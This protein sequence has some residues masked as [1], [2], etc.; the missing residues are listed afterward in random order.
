[1][2][3]LNAPATQL[4]AT[5]CCCCGR[6][7]VDAVSVELG[8]GPECRAGYDGNINEAQRKQC[9]NLTHS[10]AVAAQEGNIEAVRS[11]ANEVE[12]LGLPELAAKIRKRFINAERQAKIIITQNG[13]VISV[14]TPYKRSEKAEFTAAWRAIP[15]RRWFNGRNVIPDTSKRELWEL[16][17]RFFPGQ[18]AKGPQG[19]FK[20]P[21]SPTKSEA[22]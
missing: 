10:A 11:F 9:N 22:A 4:L 14:K 18:Y 15:G 3:Y 12:A 7:L 19:I 2:S 20:I 6:S 5:N 1:M 8:I 16:L 13:N 17:K 21:A